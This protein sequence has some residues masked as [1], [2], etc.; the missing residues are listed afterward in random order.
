MVT[1]LH[2]VNRDTDP[3][4]KKSSCQ[5]QNKTKKEIKENQ[6]HVW[7][8]VTNSLPVA[9]QKRRLLELFLKYTFIN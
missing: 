9:I 6:V 1:D 4:D 8:F 3:P 5:E 7:S 2:H